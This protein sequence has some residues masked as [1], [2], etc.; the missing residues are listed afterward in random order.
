[1]ADCVAGNAPDHNPMRHYTQQHAQLD[2]DYYRQVQNLEGIKQNSLPPN[3]FLAVHLIGGVFSN[4]GGIVGINKTTT[5]S[6]SPLA[7]TSTL[8]WV[9]LAL[10]DKTNVRR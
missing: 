8:A 5:S 10:A 3:S 2:R 1:M 4:R 9:S 7:S 6:P